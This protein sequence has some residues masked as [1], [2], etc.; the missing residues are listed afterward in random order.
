VPAGA[1]RSRPP[2]G[3]PAVTDGRDHPAVVLPPSW[4]SCPGPPLP[5]DRTGRPG[6]GGGVARGSGV[7]SGRYC[8]SHISSRSRRSASSGPVSDPLPSVGSVIGSSTHEHGRGVPAKATG[9]HGPATAARF[10]AAGRQGPVRSGRRDRVSTAR[11]LPSAPGAAV[12]EVRVGA[13]RSVRSGR[14]GPVGV[15]SGCGPGDAAGGRGR[16]RSAPTVRRG[17]GWPAACSERQRPRPPANR[18]H[19][20]DAR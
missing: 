18:T 13:A 9:Q 15:T 1:V 10:G 20:A 7:R 4:C 6:T 19:G 11:P 2:R 8:A 17:P 12:R 16:A 5:P 3:G 14:C